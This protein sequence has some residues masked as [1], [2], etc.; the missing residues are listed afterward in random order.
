MK[1][2]KRYQLVADQGEVCE[3]YESYREAFKEYQTCKEPKTLYG[4]T[5]EGK[6]SVILSK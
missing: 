5:L 3:D 2:Y 4:I 1:K 6:F